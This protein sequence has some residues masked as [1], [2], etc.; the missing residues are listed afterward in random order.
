MTGQIIQC[1]F[2]VIGDVHSQ[3]ARLN[4]DLHFRC[5][6]VKQDVDGIVNQQDV[7]TINAPRISDGVSML[8]MHDPLHFLNC[9]LQ[10]LHHVADESIQ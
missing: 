9:L 5:R 4:V 7:G 8:L 3:I 2:N 10:R 1:N 6:Y